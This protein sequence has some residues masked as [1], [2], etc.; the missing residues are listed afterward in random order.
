M[1][2]KVFS[3]R[4]WVM[5]SVKVLYTLCH[6][7]FSL[8]DTE[9]T[10]TA[11]W[12]HGVLGRFE[13]GGVV[14]G[15][16]LLCCFIWSID[17]QAATKSGVNKQFRALNPVHDESLMIST[18]ICCHIISPFNHFPLSVHSEQKKTRLIHLID[19]SL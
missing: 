18:Q 11:A 10:S 12:E 5:A 1:Y 8:T 4:G 19:I 15:V 14:G 13:K 9:D 2:I 3:Y 17:R 16:G 6:T 7:S